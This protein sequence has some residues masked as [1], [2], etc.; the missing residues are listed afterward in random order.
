MGEESAVMN[1]GRIQV[2][3]AHCMAIHCIQARCTATQLANEHRP[4]NK[5]QLFAA[6][7]V[8]VH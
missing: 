7:S 5:G 1:N 3:S 8:E 4:I 6:A 2:E